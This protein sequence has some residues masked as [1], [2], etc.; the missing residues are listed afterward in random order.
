MM[1]ARFTDNTDTK[2]SQTFSL[3]VKSHCYSNTLTAS[4]M[5]TLSFTYNTVNHTTVYYSFTDWN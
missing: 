4:T 2:A 5:P 3:T 1:T